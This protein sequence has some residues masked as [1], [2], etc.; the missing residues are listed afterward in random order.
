M[1]SQMWRHHVA[2][3]ILELGWEGISKV[4]ELVLTDYRNKFQI[5]CLR[6]V[7]LEQGV[8]G[9]KKYQILKAIMDFRWKAIFYFLLS[10]C[11]CHL[12]Y[13]SVRLGFQ[14]GIWNSLDW[15]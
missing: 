12:V 4:V 7:A 2:S 1:R 15:G 3:F 8:G 6:T 14:A 11:R 5:F 13:L 9:T 10:T